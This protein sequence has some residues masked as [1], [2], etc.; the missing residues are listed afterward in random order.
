MASGIA[1]KPIPCIPSDIDWSRCF[2]LSPNGKK[3]VLVRNNIGQGTIARAVIDVQLLLALRDEDGR[4]PLGDDVPPLP[5]LFRSKPGDVQGAGTDC[6]D[7]ALR[8]C[9]LNCA[10]LEFNEMVSGNIRD[11]LPKLTQAI[12]LY[13]LADMYH[14]LTDKAPLT[15]IERVKFDAL[16]EFICEYLRHEMRGD[17]ETSTAS[18]RAN[19]LGSIRV[20]CG[21]LGRVGQTKATSGFIADARTWL[22]G[23][24]RT[25]LFYSIDPDTSDDIE[26]TARRS[27]EK[28][29]LGRGLRIENAV[30]TDLQKKINNPL[31]NYRHAAGA[32][33]VHYWKCTQETRLASFTETSGL[34]P[35]RDPFIGTVYTNSP[36]DRDG[37]LA[38]VGIGRL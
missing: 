29:S 8:R 13:L 5:F 16:A 7:Y 30:M 4:V 32:Y 10:T 12:R 34:F 3:T 28:E 25:W 38:A 18:E 17:P 11:S 33:D 14:P 15:P 21:A 9:F 20:M 31:L 23:N 22:S 2:R 24:A 26:V 6:V 19:A 37:L 27:L 36:R 1:L 35:K